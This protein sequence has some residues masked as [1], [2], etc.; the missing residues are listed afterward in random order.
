MTVEKITPSQKVR[1]RYYIELDNGETLRADTA[2]IADFALYRGRELTDEE[3][4]R[5]RGECETHSARARALRILGSRS[6][7]RAEMARRLVE[8]G[9]SELAAEDAVAWLE[10]VGMINDAEYAR[11]LARH[12]S[13]R[14]YG[15]R[16]IRDELYKRR[17]PRGLW[18]DALGALPED[19]G[20]SAAV[21]FIKSKLRGEVP[22]RE[23]KKRVS[24]ALARR[25]FS[26]DDISSAWRLYAEQSEASEDSDYLE[27]TES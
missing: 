17:I 7:S 16:R 3:L 20:E 1:D 18:D 24:D 4:E 27:D 19:S 5:L 13:S 10:R 25:G 15:A 21:A 26:W 12:Y 6:M 11:A 14:G 23:D 9:E 8:K 22:D 2:L